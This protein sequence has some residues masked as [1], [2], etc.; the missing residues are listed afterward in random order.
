METLLDGKAVAAALRGELKIE[1]ARLTDLLGRPPAL[2][3]LQVGDDEASAVY[4]SRIAKTLG[5]LGIAVRSES[6]PAGASVAEVQDVLRR[7]GQSADIDGIL[8]LLPVPPPLTQEDVIAALDPAK[9][10]DTFIP[11]MRV[12]SSWA[13]R[14]S[15]R[16]LPPEEW[17]S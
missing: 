17:R 7:L 12:G 16:T 15:S 9:D 4:A 5:G 8:P 13:R 3:T 1:S 6:L 14:P 11:R 10:V 2:A